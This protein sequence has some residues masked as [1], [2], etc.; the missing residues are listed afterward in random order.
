MIVYDKKE[1]KN[2]HKGR[3]KNVVGSV[4]VPWRYLKLQFNGLAP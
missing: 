4:Y 2:V 3:N 1:I